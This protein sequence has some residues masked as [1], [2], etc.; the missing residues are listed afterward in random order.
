MDFDGA[1]DIAYLDRGKGRWREKGKDEKVFF[2]DIGEPTD[3]ETS[4]S[5]KIN[6]VSV[7]KMSSDGAIDVV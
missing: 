4:E 1:C 5:G 7:E 3:T 6:G 2:R